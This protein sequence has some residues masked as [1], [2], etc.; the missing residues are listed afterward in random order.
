MVNDQ[1]HKETAIEVQSL[2]VDL[3]RYPNKDGTPR[4]GF[5]D[6]QFEKRTLELQ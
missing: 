6:G 3:S 2:L 1:T 5:T 4:M